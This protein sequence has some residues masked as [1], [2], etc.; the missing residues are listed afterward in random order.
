MGTFLRHSVYRA[1]MMCGKQLTMMCCVGCDVR[2]HDERLSVC[3]SM[4]VI[5]TEQRAHGASSVTVS[6]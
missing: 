4:L 1:D 5:I 2:S 3:L 6:R